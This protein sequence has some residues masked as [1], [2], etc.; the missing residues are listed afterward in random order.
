MLADDILALLSVLEATTNAV[1]A[2]HILH[3]MYQASAACKA[4]AR[5]SQHRVLASYSCT[6]TAWP[7][8]AGAPI[9]SLVSGMQPHVAN[10]TVS[11]PVCFPQCVNRSD[12][13]ALSAEQ[14]QREAA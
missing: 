14:M 9:P 1:V 2:S 10:D 4:I 6:R 11:S 13:T 12:Q 5:C 3:L 8:A 7:V